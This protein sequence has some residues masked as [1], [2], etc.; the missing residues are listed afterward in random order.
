MELR[1]NPRAALFAFVG[2]SSVSA[3]AWYAVTHY[4][5]NDTSSMPRG[6]YLLRTRPPARGDIVLLPIPPDARGLIRERQYLP[7]YANALL[8]HLVALPGDHVCFRS[9]AFEVNGRTLAPIASADSQGRPLHPSSFCGPLPPG[10]AAVGSPYPNSFDSRY[11]GPV[12]L[13]TL[14]TATPLTA[15]KETTPC[16]TLSASSR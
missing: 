15:L 12:P 10:F 7:T 13:A 16:S 2:L 4:V 6:L 9:G 3:S 5:Y 8:K 11:F 1:P 14:R